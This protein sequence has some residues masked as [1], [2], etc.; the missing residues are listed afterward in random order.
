[1]ASMNRVKLDESC[2]YGYCMKAS[3]S[4]TSRKAA[5]ADLAPR[6]NAFLKEQRFRFIRDIDYCPETVLQHI[7]YTKSPGYWRTMV[8]VE[9]PVLAEIEQRQMEIFD[10]RGIQAAIDTL[11]AN[12][13]KSWTLAEIDILIAESG[14]SDQ[15]QTGHVSLETDQRFIDGG[16]LVYYEQGSGKIIEIRTPR[17]ENKQRFNALTGAPSNRLNIPSQYIL[18][19]YFE[20]PK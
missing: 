13:I 10:S 8:Y 15:V 1:M 5:L 16:Y 7:V 11:K 19:V 14:I 2:I 9:K 12:I 4:L 17:D 6:L 3:D 20:E 18:W